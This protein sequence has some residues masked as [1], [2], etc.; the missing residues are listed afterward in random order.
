MGVA[1]RMARGY[2]S[3]QERWMSAGL[4]RCACREWADSCEPAAMQS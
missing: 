4:G 2:A 3:V 1:P